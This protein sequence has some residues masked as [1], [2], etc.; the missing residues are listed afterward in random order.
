MRLAEKLESLPAVKNELAAST[1]GYTKAREIVKVAD[2]TTEKIGWRRP[3]AIP[4]RAGRDGQSKRRHGETQAHG[5]SRSDGIGAPRQ[6]RPHRRLSAPVRVSFELT[7]SQ[8]ARYEALMA[9][10]GRRATSPNCCW[11]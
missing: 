2:P 10:I 5:Q 3:Q 7:P 4:A 6:I 11:T 9:G 8:Y 1:L